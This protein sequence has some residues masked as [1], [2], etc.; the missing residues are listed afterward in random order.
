MV[1]VDTAV[2]A[3]TEV[4]EAAATAEGSVVATAVAMEAT[5]LAEVT[6]ALTW[7]ARAV[8]T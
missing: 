6:E 5:T 3:V 1:T 7:V 4:A 8:V 2:T